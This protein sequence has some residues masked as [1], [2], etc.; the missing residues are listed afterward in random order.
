MLFKELLRVIPPKTEITI[1]F[2]YNENEKEQYDFCIPYIEAN[3]PFFEKLWD[4]EVI[5]VQPYDFEIAVNLRFDFE[6]KEMK[7]WYSGK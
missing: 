3:L 5:K 4:C 7:R 2:V 6:N 1:N